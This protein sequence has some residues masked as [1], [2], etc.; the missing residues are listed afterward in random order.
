MQ[1]NTEQ[2]TG[3]NVTAKCTTLHCDASGMYVGWVGVCVM[4]VRVVCMSHGEHYQ[5]NYHYK[6]LY[7][8]QIVCVLC[9]YLLHRYSPLP[10]P[11][12]DRDIVQNIR[13]TTDEASKTTY[14]VALN[15]THPDAPERPKVVRAETLLSC[16]IVRP[17][18][19]D[20]NSSVVT[21]I[22]H[23]DMKGMLPEFVVKS[24]IVSYG[25]TW[26]A[27]AVKFYHEVYLKEKQ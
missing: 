26:R 4:G 14:W 1:E 22:A 10:F 25:D 11:C 9:F 12:S 24:S 15:A 7:S 16:I 23:T 19:K 20:P 27:V 5:F 21:T 6:K 18:D 3:E 17:D 2:F 8:I 13:V